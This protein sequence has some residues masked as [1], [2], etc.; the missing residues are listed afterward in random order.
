MTAERRV[1][2]GCGNGRADQRNPAA[3]RMWVTEVGRRQRLRGGG[4]RQRQRRRFGG[5]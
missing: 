5:S 4:W 3:Q 2:M 1:A